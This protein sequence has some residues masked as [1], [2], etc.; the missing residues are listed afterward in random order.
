MTKPLHQQTVSLNRDELLAGADWYITLSDSAQTLVKRDLI[1]RHVSSGDALGHQGEIQLHWFGVMDGLLKWSVSAIDG[2]SV[3][4]GGQSVGS[5]FGEGTLVRGKPRQSD[6][7]ALRHSR[8]AMLPR[9]T[10]NW[11]RQNEPAFNEFLLRQINERMHWFMGSMAAH[12][13][14]DAEHLVVRALWGLVHPLLNPLGLRHL[15]IS[16]EELANLAMVSRQRCNMTLV[17][18][19]REGLIEL[20][21]GA[22]SI[23]DVDALAAR[24]R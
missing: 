6:I 4:L 8:V 3:T 22:I 16:Q 20:G 2:R 7:I 9:T 1:E 11:L 12:R 5:W 15:L 18:L 23:R 21:Y 10:F 24:I 17:T 14:L 13:L 19:K